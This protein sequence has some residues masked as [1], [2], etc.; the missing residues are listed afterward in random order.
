[1]CLRVRVVYQCGCDATRAIPEHPD[2]EIWSCHEYTPSCYEY[3]ERTTGLSCGYILANDCGRPTCKAVRN[4][5]GWRVYNGLAN[6]ATWGSFVRCYD[7]W[8][9]AGANNQLSPVVINHPHERAP[10]RWDPRY[11]R[12]DQP[13]FIFMTQWN[14]HQRMKNAEDALPPRW[15][16][17]DVPNPDL[18]S[19]Y[20]NYPALNKRILEEEDPR[21]LGLEEQEVRQGPRRLTIGQTHLLLSRM[22]SE[23]LLYTI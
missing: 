12:Y 4:Y 21:P 20:G 23:G 10:H 22:Y 18:G 15:P 11:P 19:Y 17:F 2:Y 9:D 13:G 6:Q 14:Q 8:Y 7:R 3:Y 1:M 5:W 16:V